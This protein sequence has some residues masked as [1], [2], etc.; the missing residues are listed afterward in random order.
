MKGVGRV[1]LE[2]TGFVAL[3]WCRHLVQC[4]EH[5][6]EHATFDMLVPLPTLACTVSAAGLAR[7]SFKAATVHWVEETRA[8]K[9]P[10]EHDLLWVSSLL[11]VTG[12]I[13]DL[14][15][16]SAGQAAHTCPEMDAAVQV[17]RP[18]QCAPALRNCDLNRLGGP[19]IQSPR[20]AARRRELNETL[21]NARRT[22]S[23]Y[24]AKL[25]PQV[26]CQDIVGGLTIG[27]V[28]FAQTLA[29]AAIATTKPA[30]GVS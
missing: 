1:P 12:K 23:S 13:E 9:R 21:S 16:R 18:F 17:F 24:A 6:V 19:T 26:A 7:K 27:M 2:L 30:Q 3:S 29:H 25:L 22:R 4:K 8:L 5:E 11:L 14:T 28:C 15:I 20:T 10:R